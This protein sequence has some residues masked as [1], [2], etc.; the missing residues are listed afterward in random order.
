MGE[1]RED[2]EQAKAKIDEGFIKDRS[3]RRVAALSCDLH[4]DAA[5]TSGGG[6]KWPRK[7][8][9]DAS[10]SDQMLAVSASTVGEVAV[11]FLHDRLAR[12]PAW[13]AMP[14]ISLTGSL[15]TL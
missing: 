8:L 6:K 1:G 2:A 9:A 5:S 4:Y 10:F 15:A 11:P 12:E 13:P 3:R 7:H 14:A